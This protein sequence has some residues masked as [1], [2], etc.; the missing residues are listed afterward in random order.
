MGV[1]FMSVTYTTPPL[2]VNMQ[3]NNRQIYAPP[4]GIQQTNR[5]KTYVYHYLP[6]QTLG[7]TIEPGGCLLMASKHPDW[8]TVGHTRED[9]PDL[10]RIETHVLHFP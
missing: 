6:T 2:Y 7:T 3:N 8:L 4:E 5:G 1:S 9:R 10:T